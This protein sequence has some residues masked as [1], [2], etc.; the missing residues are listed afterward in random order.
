VKGEI[1]DNSAK[2]CNQYEYGFDTQKTEGAA[3]VY[4]KKLNRQQG[5]HLV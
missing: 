1:L 3:G 4:I 2:S 5:K